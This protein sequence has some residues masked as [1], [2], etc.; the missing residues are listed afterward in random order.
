MPCAQKSRRSARMASYS[1]CAASP[2]NVRSGSRSATSRSRVSPECAWSRF[3]SP[4]VN[5][6][7]VGIER[8]EGEDVNVFG[9]EPQYGQ[10]P[11][12]LGAIPQWRCSA[13]T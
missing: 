4:L 7:T 10:A 1:I 12:R 11:L 2:R 9:H 3:R 8:D 5:S 6:P 13:L